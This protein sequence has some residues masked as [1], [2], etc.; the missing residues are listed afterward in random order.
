[1]KGRCWQA[2]RSYYT[3]TSILG[4]LLLTNNTL[5][6]LLNQYTGMT[7]LFARLICRPQI[8]RQNATTTNK[9]AIP[10][11]EI[12]LRSK[13]QEADKNGKNCTWPNFN[14]WPITSMGMNLTHR[15]EWKVAFLC[16]DQ[17]D[18]GSITFSDFRKNGRWSDWEDGSV[19]DWCIATDL[20][21][22]L[23]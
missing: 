20:L 4:G 19:F 8:G 13:F 16:M 21:K 14:I 23:R 5:N 2:I 7:I 18:T 12:A 6:Q 11:A 17:S 22:R 15:W 1:M 3:A 10:L 9:V